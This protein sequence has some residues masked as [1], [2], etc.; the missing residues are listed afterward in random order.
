MSAEEACVINVESGQ[1][2]CNP[3]H[4]INN[5]N[6]RKQGI[7]GKLKLLLSAVGEKGIIRKLKLLLSVVF[8]TEEAPDED[9]LYRDS[10]TLLIISGIIM[11]ANYS[12][13]TSVP[14]NQG[15]RDEG[16][17]QGVLIPATLSLMTMLFIIAA[18]M[19]MPKFSFRR[20]KMQVALGIIFTAYSYINF[21]AMKLGPI[22]QGE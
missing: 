6:V 5:Q 14:S 11:S 10:K 13:I 4:H 2:V 3:D 8:C 18:Q 9:A 16:V 7:I 19:V 20:V 17:R 21:V 22:S 15:N 12:A 1:D